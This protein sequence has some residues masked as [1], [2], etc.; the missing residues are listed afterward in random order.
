MNQ[1]K[2]SV[3]EVIN[4]K[5]KQDKLIN[6]LL[7]TI[8]EWWY[9]WVVVFCWN[10]LLWINNRGECVPCVP[11]SFIKDWKVIDQDSFDLCQHMS[12]KNFDTK[13]SLFSLQI[14]LALFSQISIEKQLLLSDDDKYVKNEVAID[15]LKQGY[16][17]IPYPYRYELEKCLGG[18][19][20]VKIHLSSITSILYDRQWGKGKYNDYLVSERFLV[21]RFEKR[22]QT[23][24]FPSYKQ[25]YNDL[26]KGFTSCSLE[27]FH[28]LTYFD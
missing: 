20:K 7:S 17:A 2:E 13:F 11:E 4:D 26:W 14:W 3:K 22:K 19:E 6:T 27:L 24:S 18:E 9:T 16:S 1:Y 15:Y 21:R 28:L 5:Q 23:I 12:N 10:F 8:D 25:Y